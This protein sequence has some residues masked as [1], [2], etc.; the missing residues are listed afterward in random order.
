VYGL[1]AG[2]PDVQDAGIL[3]SPT[4]IAAR[5]LRLYF[6]HTSTVAWPLRADLPR[7]LPDRGPHVGALA[8]PWTHGS[9]CAWWPRPASRSVSASARSVGQ[10]AIIPLP[11]TTCSHLGSLATP[12]D[13][14]RAI[15]RADGRALSFLP[16][17]P[18]RSDAPW[19]TTRACSRSRGEP[20][21]YGGG[22]ADRL[23]FASALW[24]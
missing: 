2:R 18:G 13:R 3:T 4:V 17:L 11:A 6:L 9:R 16:P 21:R 10:P 23:V 1:G 20:V 8:R 14:H 7:V 5:H 24:G 22:R 12:D 19:S 15:H